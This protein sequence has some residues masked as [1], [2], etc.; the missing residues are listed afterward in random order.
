MLFRVSARNFNSDGFGKGG[1]GSGM[2]VNAPFARVENF[3]VSGV[4]DDSISLR[5]D[6]PSF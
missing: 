1:V 5:W 3:M 6:T 2:A 4:T